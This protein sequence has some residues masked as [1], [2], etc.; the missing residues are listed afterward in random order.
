[1]VPVAP[2]AKTFLITRTPA[3]TSIG[4]AV[5]DG[6]IR[7]IEDATGAI[8]L[9]PATLRDDYAFGPGVAASRIDLYAQ[10]GAVRISNTGTARIAALQIAFELSL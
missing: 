1:M 7:T 10:A 6:I 2:F 9:S 8:L 4:V 3:T 5:A